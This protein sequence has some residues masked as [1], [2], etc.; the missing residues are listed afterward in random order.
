MRFYCFRS[1]F[2]P[3]P[4]Q[5][6]WPLVAPAGAVMVREGQT[7]LSP[8]SAPVSA[9][10]TA[11]SLRIHSKHEPFPPQRNLHPTHWDTASLINT[12]PSHGIRTHPM[13]WCT[14]LLKDQQPGGRRGSFC[15]VW[16][17]ILL[18]CLQTTK[19]CLCVAQQTERTPI[20]LRV[21]F[22]SRCQN[23]VLDLVCW[24]LLCTLP[25]V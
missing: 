18:I 21:F 7:T 16:S 4:L 2:L 14:V 5:T 25:K 8:A 20:D 12:E 17:I 13:V 22:I 3:P 1:T 15:L 9:R 19:N 24:L 23:L 11:I 6:A 10:S